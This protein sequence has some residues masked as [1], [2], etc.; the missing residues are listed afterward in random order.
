MSD[1]R[2]IGVFDSGVGGTTVLR[3]LLSA[4]NKESFIYLGDTARLPYGSKSPETIRRYSEQCVRYLRKRE[5]KA[6]VIACNSASSQMLENEFE[7]IPIYNV[8]EPGA[9]LALSISQTGH[10]GVLGTRATVQSHAYEKALKSLSPSIKITTQVCPLF[11]PL[12]EEGLDGDPITNLIAYRY[13]GPL[14]QSDI[15]TLILGCTHYPLLR[16]S[17]ER[18]TTQRI[19]LVDSGD[20]IAQLLKAD[21]SNGDK[22]KPSG[23]ERGSLRI[24]C[25]DMSEN[26]VSQCRKIL[27]PIV[28]ASFESVD[29]GSLAP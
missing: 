20:A 29:I 1:N 4:V 10:I 9:K 26:F 2:P 16:Q 25:T 8:I 22:I 3:S 11:V 6:V 5:V 17:I 28:P 19:S 7:G 13:I 18:V 15:D 12:A 27:S 24:L 23:L 14:L 21:I